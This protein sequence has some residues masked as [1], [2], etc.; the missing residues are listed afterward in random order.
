MTAST[1]STL[2]F[3]DLSI[4]N[5]EHLTNGVKPGSQVV[6]LDTAQDGVEQITAALAHH[7][8]VEQVH[9]VT[10]GHAGFLQLGAT[11][12]D[13]KTLQ[14]RASE[15]R[16]WSAA[17][18]TQAR[19]FLYGCQVAATTMGEAFVTQIAPLTGVEVNASKTLMGHWANGGNW[20]FEF[21]TG[22]LAS[23]D[24]IAFQPAA[25]EAFPG[26]LVSEL[27]RED[28][29]GS[30]VDARPW[31]SGPGSNT[32]AGPFL[33]A[34]DGVAP[35]VTAPVALN[36]DGEGALRLTNNEVFQSAFVIYDRALPSNEGLQ[37]T[38]ELFAYNSTTGSV[39]ADGISF[40]L[41]DG[42]T[43][44]TV[45]GG[46]G[47]SL[48]Y[49]NITPGNPNFAAEAGI[50]GGYVGIGF[51]EFGN[52]SSPTEDRIGGIGLTPDSIAV[53]GSQGQG[54]RYLRGTNDLGE[55]DSPTVTD[56]D[57]SRQT[58]RVS[59]SNTGFLSVEFDLNRN[60]TFEA[61]EVVIEPFDLAQEN[62]Q[63]LPSSFKF[64]FAAST[65]DNTNIHEVRNL[66]ITTTTNSPPTVTDT[67]LNVRPGNAVQLTGLSALD[68]DTDGTIQFVALL[69]LPPADQ[70]TLYLGDP[71]AGGTAI[72][73]LPDSSSVLPGPF[74]RLTPDQLNQLFFVSSGTFTGVNLSYTA[75]DNLNE[76]ST[77]PGQITVNRLG[78]TGNDAPVVTNT[79][80]L[81]ERGETEQLTELSATD[82]DGTVQ[83]VALLSLPNPSAGT[84]FL[85]NPDNGGVPITELNETS[86][87]VNGPFY[88]L[89]T[90][91]LGRL[92]FR[93][94]DQ[95]ENTE[96]TINYVA[97]DNEDA[98]SNVGIIDV[99]ITG[100]GGEPDPVCEPGETI[101]GTS[102][103]DDLSGGALADTIR[104]FG[105]Q[106][107]LRGLECNDL[108]YGG[109]GR[110]TLYGNTES[111]TLFGR[112]GD[113]KLFGGQG[114]D[115][116]QGGF[117]LDQLDGGLGRDRLGGGRGSDR[118]RGRKGDDVLR[119]D[120]GNDSI[121]GGGGSDR[122]FGGQ[123]DDEISGGLGSDFA[124]GKFGNDRING[125]Q[126]DDELRGGLGDD[127]I[128]G[129]DGNDFIRGGRGNDRLLGRRNDDIIYGNDSDDL[130]R[131][132][133]G[134]DR[135]FGND[136]DD[137]LNGGVGSDI[138]LGGLGSDVLIGRGGGDRFTY[139]RLT[140][141]GDTIVDF[142]P[143][144][145]LIELG[146]LFAKPRYQ[147]ADPFGDFVRL[148]AVTAGLEI[149]IDRGGNAP[150]RDF[151]TLALLEGLTAGSV[152]ADSFVVSS[153]VV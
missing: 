127:Q 144:E 92:F 38:F 70:G 130:M 135:A 3:V 120:V 141:K 13:S 131:G 86:P 84:L 63:A 151:V 122:M 30:D 105:G 66:V 113:D 55:L 138:L 67:R 25:L 106:D 150:G 59:L 17:L 104:G 6:L 15:L 72:T 112:R 61:N 10:H 142:T 27:F 107:V 119:G 54:Y 98:S 103:N 64:G 77:T 50:E 68:P 58:A 75:V 46:Y 110:D 116:L 115:Q 33:T 26:V 129:L 111:D 82:P 96:F 76:P 95:A 143:G 83:F 140:E 23:E 81:I 62:G 36:T 37:I 48:G 117:G 57:T 123:G 44:P 8:N 87:L 91:Q 93:S 35:S 19:I 152:N 16:Q 132:A 2:V 102:A 5:Y 97:V 28:F 100:T 42:S 139:E 114:A 9:I 32:S 134:N 51:D 65:G 40:F 53:R 125:G 18:T 118:L 128:I 137:R 80:V 94:N 126:G 148:R 52:F 109:G 22:K 7:H 60:G 146:A 31:I 47:G 149:R 85:R 20:A 49:A 34:R 1:A 133:R 121:D 39:G 12:L 43:S 108:I 153:V 89:T 101:L 21:S 11:L 56:R 74:L 124:R 29:R 69:A 88:R 145:D 24:A 41:I 147:S 78:G 79:R 73:S 90:Q 4:N 136:G 99:Q 45:A 71:N 14:Q